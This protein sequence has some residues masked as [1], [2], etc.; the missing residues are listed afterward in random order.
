MA[1]KKSSSKAKKEEVVAEAAK[2]EHDGHCHEELDAKITALEGKVSD[3]EKKLKGL[4]DGIEAASKL[5]NE[6][7]EAKSKLGKEVQELQEKAKSWKE[8]ADTNN[9]G[10]LSFEEIWE[11]ITLRNRGK[12]HK[13]ASSIAKK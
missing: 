9:D 12:S 2:T 7:D 3:L 8:K 11:Y 13:R 4:L 10:S 5:K 6:L 1:F